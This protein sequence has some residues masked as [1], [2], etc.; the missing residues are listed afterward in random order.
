MH[1]VLLRAALLLLA[2]SC[3]LAQVPAQRRVPPP[4]VQPLV[5][6]ADPLHEAP[7]NVTIS[8]LT[9]GTGPAVWQMFGH[10]AIWIHDNVTRRDSVFN[11]GVFDSRQPY[12]IP[13]FLKGLMLYQ[14]GGE[15]LDEV[16][17][18]YRYFNRDVVSQE[19]DLTTAQKDTI[20]EIIRVNAQPENLKYRYDYFRN[21][22]STRPRDILDRALGGQIRAQ[23]Q[24]L[25]DRTYRSEALRLM[26]LNQPLVTGVDI[27]LGEPADHQLTQWED[28]FLPKELHDFVGNLQV[29]DSTGAT[30]PLVRSRV[31]LFQSTRGPEPASP[32]NMVLWLWP[33]GIVIALLIV[34]LAA[35]ATSSQG[36]R[37]A[38]AIVACI[39]C[40]VAGL[41]GVILTALWAVTDHMFAHSNENLLV[42]SPFW[43]V[44]A[45]LI[46]IYLTSGRA[47]GWMR[48]FAIGLAA[49]A[50]LELIA[51]VIGIARQNNL[52]VVGLVLFPA[53]A[54]VWAS[55]RPR[56][57]VRAGR[58]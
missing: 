35:A 1:R 46:V 56:V 41:L 25:V 44:L 36:A 11:W 17:Y 7:Q 15:T 19:L 40:V 27:G 48:G 52:A 34:A 6:P 26:Q 8:L 47:A 38:A 21:N 58:G 29:K 3:L 5:A 9:M 43:L 22:C 53:L 55:T 23:S 30:H 16:L 50:A 28:M 33:L 49:L 31:V 12:F 39:W 51:H 42:F 10:S 2:P 57:S 32:P 24:R 18:E 54:I 45:I 4:V 14:M 20:L 13:R 37:R